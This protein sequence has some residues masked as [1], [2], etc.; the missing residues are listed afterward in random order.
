[1][2]SLLPTHTLR[3]APPN[4]PGGVL[5]PTPHLYATSTPRLRGRRLAHTFAAPLARRLDA[6]SPL[7]HRQRPEYAA[8]QGRG[9]LDVW[10]CISSAAV[11]KLCTFDQ[12]SDS[13]IF[14]L[15]QFEFY[16]DPTSPLPNSSFLDFERLHNIDPFQ[17]GPNTTTTTTTG[18][19]PTPI[20][21][22]HPWRPPFGPCLSPASL[23]P[24]RLSPTR[25]LVSSLLPPNLR[26]AH[27]SLT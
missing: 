7:C 6:A 14:S 2:P 5:P 10:P 27:S 3:S 18:C 21:F 22:A 20:S 13:W 19:L 26:H 17:I 15:H 23:L 24:A 11:L 1:M 8:L 25:R 9:R 4:T 16:L 12:S